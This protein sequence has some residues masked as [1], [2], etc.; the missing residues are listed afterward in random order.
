MYTAPAAVH[1]IAM[2]D[3]VMNTGNSNSQPNAVGSTQHGS[4]RQVHEQAVQ[5]GCMRSQAIQGVR[6]LTH[7]QAVQC[8]CMHRHSR[9][10]ARQYR[11]GAWA[12]THMSVAWAGQRRAGCRQG[13]RAGGAREEEDARVQL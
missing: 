9:A 2:H 11:A 4:T 8:R 7:G 6:Y 3:A 1:D 12:R 10:F 13:L 5:S